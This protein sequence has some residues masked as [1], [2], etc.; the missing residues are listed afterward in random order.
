MNNYNRLTKTEKRIVDTLV[1]G[2][3]SNKC[4]ANYL[5]LSESAVATHFL[6]I[7]KKLHLHSRTQI[8]RVIYQEKRL[9]K[10]NKILEII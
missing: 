8:F 3:L 6:N 7:R 1:S 2:F 10:I 5:N 9:H 4:I